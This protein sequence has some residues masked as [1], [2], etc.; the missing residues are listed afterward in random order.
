MVTDLLVIDYI[1]NNYQIII[2]EKLNKS[3]IVMY[4][5]ISKYLLHLNENGQTKIPS[6]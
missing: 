4:D 2:L 6:L 1:K 5:D 3:S